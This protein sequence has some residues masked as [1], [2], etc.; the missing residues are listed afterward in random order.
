MHQIALIQILIAAAVLAALAGAVGMAGAVQLTSRR[1]HGYVHF[2]FYGM[3]LLVALEGLLSGRDLTTSALTTSESLL[4]DDGRPAMLRLLQPVLSLLMLAVT[5]ERVVSRW[6]MPTKQARPPYVLLFVFVLFWM[7]TVASPALFGANPSF[8]HDFSYSLIIGIAVLLSTEVEKDL[9]LKAARN[10]LLLFLVVSLL[11]IPFKPGLV[12][13]ATYSQG[14]FPGVPRLAG[15]AAHAVSLGVLTQ[16]ALLCLL[17]CPYK[18]RWL[19]LSAW[20]I[21]IAVLFLAQSKTAWISFFLCS[22]LII[23]TRHGPK[24][25]RRVSDPFRNDLAIVTLL[26]FMAIVTAVA[27]I[28]IFADLGDKLGRFLDSAEGAQL[29]SLTGRDRIWAIAYSEWERNPVFGYGPFIWDV[30]FRKL[31]GMPYATSAHNQFM[32]TLSRSGSVGTA[33]LVIYAVVLLVLSVRYNRASGGMTLALFLAL[34]LR[35]VSEVPLMLFG[36]G[37]ELLTHLLLLMTIAAASSRP[38]LTQRKSMFNR[39]PFPS[40]K[41]WKT[42]GRVLT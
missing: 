4:I 38:L 16:L 39:Q 9:A 29:A 26:L 32:D 20:A 11:V 22:A 35:S 21:G 40:D 12:M 33:T 41:G 27:G 15:L 34:A 10:A 28:L 18:N 6:L 42:N 36:Y 31:I 17:A 3:V 14:L 30:D 24:F 19:H 23:A 37:T 7:G 1:E 5:A 13:D 8:S 25:M 2:I